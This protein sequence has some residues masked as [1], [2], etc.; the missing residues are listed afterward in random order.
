MAKR[1]LV[2]RLDITKAKGPQKKEYIRLCKDCI[3]SK[4]TNCPFDKQV[5]QEMEL[6]EQVHMDLWGPAWVKSNG[7]AKYTLIMTDSA[8]KFRKK[9]FLSEKS[10]DM[11]L[12]AV[13]HYQAEAERQTGKKLKCLQMDMGR[14]FLNGTVEGWCRENG[15]WIKTLAPYTH[16]S[17]GVT[18]RTNQTVI[19][20]LC[21]I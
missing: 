8:S 13:K 9:Y 15:I 4:Q 11:T 2:D 19:K 16:A 7:G 5:T 1:G 21:C 20:V 18:E 17:N 10:G 12:E 3:F 6:L 14:E